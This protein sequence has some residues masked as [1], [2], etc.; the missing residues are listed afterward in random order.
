MEYDFDTRQKERD[1]E[2]AH[3]AEQDREKA[4]QLAEDARRLGTSISLYT[5][6]SPTVEQNKVIVGE[7]IGSATEIF[8]LAD[9]DY[10]VTHYEGGTAGHAQTLKKDRMMDAVLDWL[11]KQ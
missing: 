8:L 6:T 11:N 4:N 9:G 2:K 7:Q 5:Q 1:L 10:R 3:G